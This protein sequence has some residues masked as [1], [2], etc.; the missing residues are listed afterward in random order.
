M[1]DRKVATDAS[2]LVVIS[3]ISKGLEVTHIFPYFP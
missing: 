1:L 2:F 3:L